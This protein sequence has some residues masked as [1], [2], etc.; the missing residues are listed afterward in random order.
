MNT[1]SFVFNVIVLEDIL[2]IINILS[3]QLQ[4]KTATLGNSVSVINGVIKTIKDKRSNKAFSE[5]WSN[6]KLYAEE[7]DV[8]IYLQGGL[9]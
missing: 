2:Q 1:V 4:Q 6:V 5:I 8:D 7:N 3:V 9:A